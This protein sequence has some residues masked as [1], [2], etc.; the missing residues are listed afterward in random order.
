[1]KNIRII[2]RLDIKGPNVVKG[3]HLEGLRV[4]GNPNDFAKYYYEDGADELLYMDVVASLYERNSLREIV[5]H[6]AEDIFIPLTV[7]GGLRNLE[8][9]NKVL[10]AGADKISLNTAAICNPS[11]IKQTS[12]KFGSSTIMIAIEAIQQEGGQYMAFVDNGREF[13]G[14]NV[15]EW[16]QEVEYLGAG[17]I[18]LTSVDRDGTG[19]GFD[20]NLIKSV[21]EVVAIPVIAHGGAGKM[22]DVKELIEETNIDAVALASVLHY[23]TIQNI[24]HSNALLSGEGNKDFLKSGSRFSKINPFTI[25]KLK[26]YLNRNNINVR[27][28]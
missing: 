25:S 6:T 22:E 15:V 9:I 21:T 4:V 2:S 3:V 7:G 28:E 11:L 1:M 27:Y 26:A 19:L 8:D 12:E 23:D 5:E 16:A 24:D 20:I 14:K 10:R 17:E 18:L 13:T